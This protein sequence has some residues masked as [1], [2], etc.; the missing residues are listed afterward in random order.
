MR[1]QITIY[2][3]LPKLEAEIATGL[4]ALGLKPC[5]D[6]SF[7][8][9]VDAPWGWALLEKKLAGDLV[10]IVT[11][12]PCPEYKLHLLKRKPL[13]LLNNVSVADIAQVLNA[14]ISERS[15]CPN[16]FIPA[17]PLSYVE[18]ETLYL[19]VTDH[20]TKSIAKIR[21]TSV[22]YVK[23]TTHSIYLKLNLR[24]RLQL[25]H[26]YFGHWSLLL[27]AGW[28]PPPHVSAALEQYF[29]KDT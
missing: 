3:G 21:K 26:Y 5:S 18:R 8:L 29:G 16:T 20:S 15:G 11:D 14:V 1:R 7:H 13:A 10:L 27:Q 2:C 4:T 12:N 24:T 9:L 19:I 23:N 25:A 28:T 22:Q 17:T 6:G